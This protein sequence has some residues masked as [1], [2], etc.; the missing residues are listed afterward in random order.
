MCGT[1]DR[2]IPNG[3]R[4][5]GGRRSS[6]RTRS[7][8]A[9]TCSCSI[10]S[11]FQ[12]SCANARRPSSSP[13][14]ITSA[15]PVGL[16]LPVHTPPADTWEDWVEK[17]GVDPD[18]VR[19]MESEDLAWL[20]A[21]EG[22]GH[23]HGP[24]AWPFGITAHAG[25]EDNDLVLWLPSVGA[26]VT[27]DS[28]VGLRR[29]TGHPARRP[30]A[31]DAR[32]RCPA[33]PAT[34][35]PANRARAPRPRRADRPRN[36]RARSFVS[37]V[38]E[39]VARHPLQLRRTAWR[40]LSWP[41][42]TENGRDLPWRR[43]RDPYGI[44]VSEVMLQQTQVERVV[45]RYE[46]WLGRWPTA[47]ALAAASPGERHR[48][49][50]G[51]RLQPARARAPSRGMPPRRLRMADGSHRAARCRPVHRRGASGT[52]RSARTC[53]RATSTSSASS[54]APAEHSRARRPRR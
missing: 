47:A 5:S 1:G 13:P 10:R 43:T 24:G 29:R 39:R 41:G 3:T 34:A 37:A 2:R 11:P 18:R 31:C 17:F 33:A 12:A 40:R 54:G 14:P 46:R 16:G 45:P 35:R 27:G 49:V 23:F 6:R 22:E 15:T 7:R 44:L 42:S 30:Q 8:S 20:R 19:G 52:S 25:R 48:R 21:D 36:P 4:S 28:L 9:T 50:A 32:Q 53:S 51:P 38:G 26:I